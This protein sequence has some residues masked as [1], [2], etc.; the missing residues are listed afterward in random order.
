MNVKLISLTKPIA[1]DLSHFSTEDLIAH[2][3]RVSNPSNQ[4]NTET[5][6]KLLKYLIKHSHWSPFE[7]VSATVE[8]QTSRA[9]AAQILRHR[10]F[11]FQEFSQRYSKANG[12]EVYPA[13][14]QDLKNKQNSIDD[15]SEEDKRW[16]EQTQKQVAANSQ[17]AYEEA[18]NRGI[19]KEVARG[20]LPLNTSTTIYM[21][22]SLRS[23]LHYLNLRCDKD[24]QLEHREIAEA[25]KKELA[26]H[27]PNVFEAMWGEK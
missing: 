16:F 14:R 24:T 2:A 22:G 23:W 25:I 27:F 17:A 9:I 13:R 5:A 10:S 19:A 6:P 21:S 3:A 12:T 1:S 7:L 15:M 11:T 20:L 18:L 26:Q 4:M 8:I